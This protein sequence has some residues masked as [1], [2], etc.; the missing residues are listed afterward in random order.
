MTGTFGSILQ[1]ALGEKKE[2][3]AEEKSNGQEKTARE[4]AQT[5][6]EDYKPTFAEPTEKLDQLL[7]FRSI[8]PLYACFL[9]KYLGKAD[10]FEQIQLIESVLEVPG[11][12]VRDVR[13]PYELMKSGELARAFLDVELIERGLVP[14]HLLSGE[15]P[16]DP[17]ELRYDEYP[18]TVADKMRLLFQSDFPGVH[19][20]RIAPVWIVG[21]LLKF[22]GNFNKYVS[23]RDLIKQ[24]GIIFRHLL[25]FVLLLQEFLP[26]VPEGIAEEEWQTRLMFWSDTITK[27]CREV[28]P[29]STDKTLEA[30][31]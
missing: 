23:G 21:D 2:N 8:N 13:V 28:D 10:E 22:N 11:S 24:E 29:V 1:E 30:K 12:V 7:Q 26:I 14:A 15:M 27:A 20:L 6:A 18:P 31:G 3:D 5:K 9:L 19:G 17:H 4:T 16:E 25:R